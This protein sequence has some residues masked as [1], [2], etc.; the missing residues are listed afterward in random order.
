MNVITDSTFIIESLILTPV[1]SQMYQPV[2]ARPYRFVVDQNTTDEISGRLIER[3]TNI[4]S[5]DILSG[6]VDGILQPDIVGEAT[7]INQQWCSQERYA[8]RLVV[9]YVT[10]GGI[11]RRSYVV[12]F[13]NYNGLSHSHAI[14]PDMEFYINSVIETTVMSSYYGNRLIETERLYRMY[15]VLTNGSTDIQIFTQRPCD[16]FNCRNTMEALS[17]SYNADLV[18]NNS[19]TIAPYDQ[20]AICGNVGNNIGA[21]WLAKMLTAGI[22]TAQEN[23]RFMGSHEMDTQSDAS[24]ITEPVIHDNLFLRTISR[25]GKSPMWSKTSF[26]MGTLLMIDPTTDRD[27]TTVINTTG[28]YQNLD[29]LY[30]DNTADWY[31]RDATTMRAYTILQSCIGLA[32][33]YGFDRITLTASNHNDRF[34]PG[35]VCLVTDFASCMKL[36]NQE[37]DSVLNQFKSRFIQEIFN[38]ETLQNMVTVNMTCVVDLFGASRVGLSYGGAPFVWYSLPTFASAATTPIVTTNFSSL[39]STAWDST[40]CADTL[41]QTIK[42][43]ARTR[44]DYVY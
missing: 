5:T 12:G 34:N 22:A 2:I 16:L 36:S 9:S 24:A 39:E 30:G 26:K 29:Y 19:Y 1:Q 7:T 44:F 41:A 13:T 15:N 3:E 21:N 17:A 28:G 38:N 4:V 11:I 18:T 40:T 42:Y 37:V 27:K 10:A 31:G 20:R 6:L 35:A 32:M 23:D 14:D 8:F 33:S 43:H 25:L